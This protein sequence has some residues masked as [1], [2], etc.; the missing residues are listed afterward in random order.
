[1]DDLV[2]LEAQVVAPGH[3]AERI[4]DVPGLDGADGD[5][6]Q[7]RVELEEVLLVDERRVPVVAGR[8]GAAHRAG[9]VEAAEGAAENEEP[10]SGHDLD[11]T[12][13]G[14]RMSRAA[15]RLAVL[16]PVRNAG[17]WLGASLRSLMRQTEREFEV[18]AVDDG[19]SDGSGEALDAAARQD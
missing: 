4:D 16:L 12:C 5:G 2:L 17:R 10:M 13:S 19:S 1:A 9:H 7:E 6:R 15:P 14:V 11:H 8:A 18:I 3:V